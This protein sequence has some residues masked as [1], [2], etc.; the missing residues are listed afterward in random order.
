[1]AASKAG[2][3]NNLRTASDGAAIPIATQTLSTMSDFTVSQ[4]TLPDVVGNRNSR[5][6]PSCRNRKYHLNGDRWCRDSNFYPIFSATSD[7]SMTL[8][9]SPDGTDYRNSRWRPPKLEMK[10]TIERKKLATRFQRLLHTCDLA[11][12][13]CDTAT[14]TGVG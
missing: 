5:W 7:S 6:R 1:M 8:S 12:L 11:G 4:W 10:I 14:F 13:V 9:T 3:G 2:S